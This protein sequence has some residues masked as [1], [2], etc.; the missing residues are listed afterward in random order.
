MID[1]FLDLI[2]NDNNLIIETDRLVLE[3]IVESHAEKMLPMF[4]D[5]SLYN[6]I[7]QNPPTLDQLQK[8]YRAWSKRT[9]PDGSE[10]WLN[11]AAR[12]FADCN[13]VGHFQAGYNEK[14]GFSVAYT[15]AKAF[16]KKA[17]A[18]EGLGSVINFL[19]TRMQAPSIKAWV[20]T[21]NEPSIRLV[22]RLGFQQTE[23]IKCADEFK[24]AV[25]DEFVFELSQKES[26]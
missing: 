1:N 24:G 7:P 23:L 2:S 22:K 17:Y 8:R 25:S 26:K 9:S 12:T 14:D 18:T 3:P 11:W 19:R 4:L 21:R 10:I 20:D 5:E 13:Y 15:I 16:Q 6:F